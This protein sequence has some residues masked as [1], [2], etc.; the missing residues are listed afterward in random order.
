MAKTNDNTIVVKPN[1]LQIEHL[2]PRQQEGAPLLVIGTA[3]A[4]GPQA[5]LREYEQK[6]MCPHA[7]LDIDTG[8][9]YQHIPYEFAALTVPQ[10]TAFKPAFTTTSYWIMLGCLAGHILTEKQIKVV[11]KAI[12]DLAKKLEV[13][14]EFSDFPPPQSS[15]ALSSVVT[16]TQWEEIGGVIASTITP[17]C[18]WP[19]IQQ[20]CADGIQVELKLKKT[21]DIPNS[22]EVTFAEPQ[23]EIDEEAESQKSIEEAE[24]AGVTE[25]LEKMVKASEAKKKAP[26]KKKAASTKKAET[27]KES[28]EDQPSEEASE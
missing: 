11:A 5:A 6:M 15:V 12:K 1:W 26:A 27:K 18:H 17:N 23:P 4:F 3:N 14:L 22:D 8:Q 24:N 9:I 10:A 7:T 25:T 19:S 2:Q 21:L 20:C 16:A 28:T 13:P